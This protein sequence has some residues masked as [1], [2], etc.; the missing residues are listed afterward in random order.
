M[1][2]F[3]LILFLLG[4]SDRHTLRSQLEEASNPISMPSD[5]T[6]ISGTTLSNIYTRDENV[7]IF[8]YEWNNK[9]CPDNRKARFRLMTP[10][11]RATLGSA[12][13]VLVFHG[14]A[15]DVKITSPYGSISVSAIKKESRLWASTKVDDMLGNNF[16][17]AGEG[18]GSIAS[19]IAERKWSAI[20]LENCWA[21]MG[22]N[23]SSG[24]QTNNTSVDG[25]ARKG[26]EAAEYLVDNFYANPL[27]SALY[28]WGQSAGGHAAYEVHERKKAEIDKLVLDSPA[29]KA[30]GFYNA[31]TRKYNAN[32][33]TAAKAAYITA[34]LDAYF[35]RVYKATS[36]TNTSVLTTQSLVDKLQN[37]ASYLTKKFFY[38]YST[39]DPVVP[40]EVASPAA[41]EIKSIKVSTPAVASN[42]CL[43]ERSDTKHI[44]LN[45]DLTLAR[46]VVNFLE[47][48]IC[49]YL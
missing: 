44:F 45:D 8:T 2:Y 46:N 4:C 27:V 3:V 22:I 48:G 7:G 43:M 18:L 34:A 40:T 30:L 24:S 26:L 47:N 5:V 19:A 17:N 14:G 36:S 32:E 11:A 23:E 37:D 21:D 12:P 13:L 20:Y 10:L 28:V 6:Y 49:P 41:T 42:F 35:L 25:F 31:V 9:T 29:D 1:K 33:I 38:A 39:N 15:F 16:I